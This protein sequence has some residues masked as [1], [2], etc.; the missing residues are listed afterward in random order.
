MKQDTKD[1]IGA[2]AIF[3]VFKLFSLGSNYEGLIIVALALIY[4][5]IDSLKKTIKNNHS[6]SQQTSVANREVVHTKDASDVGENPISD[7]TLKK[8]DKN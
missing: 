1:L 8:G 7:I 2:L 4:W 5:K 3:G 6:P